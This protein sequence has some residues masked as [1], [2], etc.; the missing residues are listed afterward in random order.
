MGMKNKYGYQE[1]DLFEVVE[2]PYSREWFSVGSIIKLHQDDGSSCPWFELV[3]G[4]S[5]R[6][7]NTW[8]YNYDH[9]KPVSIQDGEEYVEPFKPFDVTIHIDSED[10]ARQLYTVANT[11]ISRFI[12]IDQG[13]KGIQPEYSLLLDTYRLLGSKLK[14]IRKGELL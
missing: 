8:A 2:C 14:G 4:R 10:K 1:G 7:D 11:A 9:L 12:K 5:Y 13:T 3:R 6:G